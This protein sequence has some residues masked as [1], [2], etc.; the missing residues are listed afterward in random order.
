[1][2]G[3]KGKINEYNKSLTPEQRKANAKKAAT[4]PRQKSKTIRQ[5]AREINNAPAQKKARKALQELGVA[6]EDMTNAAMIAASIFRAAF[7]GDM[8][9]IEKWEQYIGQSDDRRKDL[10]IRYLK[11]RIAMLET[12]RGCG[13][14]DGKLADLINGLKEDDP[15]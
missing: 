2:P 14:K 7:N 11:A 15:L 9:A 13:E 1:M 5:I 4:A 8:R 6:D 3:G 10:E 12:D